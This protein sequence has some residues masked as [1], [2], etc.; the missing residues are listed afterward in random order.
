[1]A[2]E[3]YSQIYTK[4]E[5]YKTK[6]IIFRGNEYNLKEYLSVISKFTDQRVR[7][8]YDDMIT[9]LNLPK[10]LEIIYK[11]LGHPDARIDFYHNKYPLISFV[12][13]SRIHKYINEYDN[14]INNADIYIGM[15]HFIAVAYTKVDKKLFFRR[16]G[17][18]NGYERE[19]YYKN[20]KH[21]V[22][23]EHFRMYDNIFDVLDYVYEHHKV[24]LSPPEDNLE[25]YV[26]GCKVEG[27]RYPLSHS[28]P[29]HTC[30]K[31]YRPGHGIMECGN[32][33]KIRILKE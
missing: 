11:L 26:I 24:V 33:D 9:E 2:Q 21:M 27:C 31:C 12:E 23:Q 5:K 1:M 20:Y 14:F 13:V 17:G 28:T 4:L 18:S 8:E 15:G 6:S 16:D 10:E 22:P 30:G 29:G 7:K 25:M 3:L 19:D 32:P